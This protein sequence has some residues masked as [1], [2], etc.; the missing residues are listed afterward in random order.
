MSAYFLG[1]MVGVA[2][3]KCGKILFHS[4]STSFVD[5]KTGMISDQWRSAIGLDCSP[6]VVRTELFSAPTKCDDWLS[7]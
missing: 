7:I 2:D 3:F 4:Y 1:K 6:S 5:F